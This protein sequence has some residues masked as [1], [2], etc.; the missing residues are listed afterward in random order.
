[1]ITLLRCH[2]V[3]CAVATRPTRKALA[4]LDAELGP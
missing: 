2:G 4:E 1:M 3:L